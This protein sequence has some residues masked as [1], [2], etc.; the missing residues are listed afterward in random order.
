MEM[1]SIKKN[2]YEVPP[3]IFKEMQAKL[4][5][6]QENSTIKISF[7]IMEKYEN[8]ARQMFGGMIA[9]AFDNTFGYFSYKMLQKACVTLELNTSFIRPTS[10][11]DNELIVEAHLVLKTK[12]KLV[13]AGKAYNPGGKLIAVCKT[14][15][16]IILED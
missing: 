5:E 3:K 13:M 8:P 2:G 12:N 11:T 14:T 10:V 9:A 1:I 6:Y 4:L 7:P 16:M 15:M